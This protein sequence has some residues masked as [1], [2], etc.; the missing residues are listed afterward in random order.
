MNI[1]TVENRSGLTKAKQL[2]RNGIIPCAIYDGSL[3]ESLSVQ[4]DQATGRQLLR[5]KR[6][7]NKVELELDGKIIPVQIKD[8]ERNFVNNEIIHIT[9]QALEAD[10]KV[11][12]K[13]PIVLENTDKV[14]GVLE[15]MLFE[16]P[17]S[18]FPADMIDSVAIDLEA[19]V[20]GSVLTL[21][22]IP[23]FKNKNINLQ[24]NSD[25]TILRISDKKR[26]VLQVAE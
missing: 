5:S 12:S 9:F 8:L 15:Q 20:V 24:L 11:N 26:S 19:L 23:A 21:E 7:G 4:I 14:V 2:R 25:S 22:D 1:I 13:V 3:G 10:K 16:V 17:Y 6:E 18:A